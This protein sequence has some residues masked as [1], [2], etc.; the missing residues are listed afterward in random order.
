M[1]AGVTKA[2]DRQ[3]ADMW[4]AFVRDRDEDTRNCLI[5]N[6]LPLVRRTAERLHA[7]L[8]DRMVLDDL[9]SAG[10]FGL[11]DAINAFDPDRGVRFETYGVRRIRGAI[12][13]ELRSV[14]WVPRLVRSRSNKLRAVI[15]AVESK[16]GRR[17]TDKE[18][19]GELNISVRKFRRAYRNSHVV[20]QISLDRGYFETDSHKD[21]REIDVLE[22]KRSDDPLGHAQR[23][24]IR[25]IV[26]H[27]LTPTE[28]LIVML[29]YFERMTM[30]KI[31]KALDLSESRVSQMH[32]SILERLRDQ[33]EKCRE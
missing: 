25:E 21:F 16:L 11:M 14:D 8:P 1:S 31:G 23:D 15:G 18:L 3:I 4:K 5:E 30:K 20:T 17:P 7:K 33:I 9:I 22:D 12:L 19:A 28:R 26:T 2:E 32:S 10:T 29:Y 6:Y 24:E 13:D 27:S